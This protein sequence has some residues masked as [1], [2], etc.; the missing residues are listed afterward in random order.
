MEKI[1]SFIAP[2]PLGE[3]F[4]FK[5]SIVRSWIFLGLCLGIIIFLMNLST[6]TINS[7]GIGAY[8]IAAPI[9]LCIFG[10][11]GLGIEK[12][13]GRTPEYTG[14]YWWIYPIATWISLGIVM[15]LFLLTIALSLAGFKVPESKK[16]NST[17]PR[18]RKI[19]PGKIREQLP[20]IT[21]GELL[22]E[23]DD[24]F[25]NEEQRNGLNNQEKQVVNKLRKFDRSR[26]RSKL[27]DS[28][29][30]DEMEVLLFLILR[31]LGVEL[32]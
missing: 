6:P 29:T 3:S 4:R 18:S 21:P 23:M 10:F 1:L 30:N 27:R 15:G 11:I 13:R 19:D 9:Q 32:R 25:K 7:S 22:D 28:L 26:L 8:I 17:R 16:R 2:L 24:L 5:L 12:I 20:D 14:W 31:L